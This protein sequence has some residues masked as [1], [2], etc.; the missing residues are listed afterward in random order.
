MVYFHLVTTIPLC[1]DIFNVNIH[2]SQHFI[3]IIFNTSISVVCVKPYHY[4]HS[5]IYNFNLRVNIKARKLS[6]LKNLFSI[7]Q[8]FH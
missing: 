6:Y 5:L 1:V 2:C 4:K 7:V 8:D 3:E